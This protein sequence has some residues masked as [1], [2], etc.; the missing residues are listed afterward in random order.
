MSPDESSK[1]IK[2]RLLVLLIV[3]VL[4]ACTQINQKTPTSTINAKQATPTSVTETPTLS[5]SPTAS[6]QVVILVAPDGA[7]ATQVS[8]VKEVLTSLSSA[9][10]MDLKVVS[11]LSQPEITLST[12]IV[13]V[14]APYTSLNEL[15]SV[16]L[17]TQFVALGIE[18]ISPAANVNI[19]GPQGFRADQQAFIAGYIA[20]IVT[21]DYRV[22]S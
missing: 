9:S 1:P 10:G 11:T 3:L 6:R 14:L 7:D 16:A 20:A 12:R 18:N 17:Q 15:A 19:I 8:A 5:P 2:Y 13:I 21:D 4:A 22:E